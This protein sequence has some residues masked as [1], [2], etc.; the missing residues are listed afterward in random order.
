MYLEDQ[1]FHG[2]DNYLGSSI[3]LSSEQPMP[4]FGTDELRYKRTRFIK[5]F[6]SQRPYGSIRGVGPQVIMDELD[7]VLE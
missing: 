3:S 6:A 1:T 5:T 2:L 4:L 7:K